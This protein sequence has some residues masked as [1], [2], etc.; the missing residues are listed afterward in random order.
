MSRKPHLVIA[1]Y[2]DNEERFASSYEAVDA[3]DAERQA[4][5]EAA[6]QGTTLI[7][8]G[9]LLDGEVIA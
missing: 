8:A 2:T 6:K 3:A 5:A 4:Q 1:T 7:V 9:V